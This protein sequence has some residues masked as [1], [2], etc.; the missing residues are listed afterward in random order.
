M[1]VPTWKQKN[2][3]NDGFFCSTPWRQVKSGETS[4]T[5]VLV[6]GL[7]AVSPLTQLVL[8][9]FTEAVSSGEEVPASLLEHL[10]DIR[11]LVGEEGNCSSRK[12]D[13]RIPA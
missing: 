11:L 10:P 9:L 1:T 2:D 12:K 3:L 8:V 4:Q 7:S 13:Q 5:G 6:R